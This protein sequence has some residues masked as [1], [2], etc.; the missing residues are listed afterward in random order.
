[1]QQ[2]V[3]SCQFVNILLHFQL[4]QISAQVSNYRPAF[5]LKQ[6]FIAHP[7]E[8]YSQI[9]NATQQQQYKMYSH[10]IQ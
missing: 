9:Y 10:E 8:Q 2:I 4:F 7:L 3:K 6:Y 5:A 1:M